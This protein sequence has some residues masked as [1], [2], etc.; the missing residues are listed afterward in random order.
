MSGKDLRKKLQEKLRE[1]RLSRLTMYARDC[2]MDVLEEK[3]ENTKNLREKSRIKKQLE[4]L[5]KMQ[6]KQDQ[7]TEFPVYD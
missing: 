4:L 5:D 6:K 2:K 3:L 1:K 7:T